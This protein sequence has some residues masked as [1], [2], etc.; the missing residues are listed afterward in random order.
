MFEHFETQAYCIIHVNKLYFPPVF[1][2]LLE[3]SHLACTSA[4][5][6]EIHTAPHNFSSNYRS[7][8]RVFLQVTCSE[9]MKLLIFVS[10]LTEI[11]ISV[12]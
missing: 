6:S 3:E 1:L 4:Y 11:H 9:A 12:D 8:C 5:R 7:F 2:L 10:S